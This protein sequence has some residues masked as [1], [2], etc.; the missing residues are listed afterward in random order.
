M[1]EAAATLGAAI[2]GDTPCIH[3]GAYDVPTHGLTFTRITV[4]DQISASWFK[5][6]D[7]TLGLQHIIPVKLQIQEEIIPVMD[8]FCFI[9]VG[10]D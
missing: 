2:G 8:F 3:S 7:D 9:S 1:E 5:A 6:S 10:L 4:K